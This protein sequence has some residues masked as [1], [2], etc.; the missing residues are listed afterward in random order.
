MCI[1][2]ITVEF[3]DYPL[4]GKVQDDVI[5][6]YKQHGRDPAVLPKL[7]QFVGGHTDFML[8]IKYLR[9]YPEKLFQLP[10]G[11]T[12]YRA[13][14]KNADGTRGFIG[15]PHKTFTEIDSKYQINTTTFISDQNKLFKAGYQVCPNPSLLHCKIE[16]D[17]L[18]DFMS[19]TNEILEPLNEE[20]KLEQ[21]HNSVLARNLKIFEEVENAGSEISCR[22]NKCQDC[23]ICKEHEQTEIMSIKEEVVKDVI[24]KS[25]S[26][27]I[28]KRIT[29][30]VL[31]FM[32]NPLG[33]LPHNKSKALQ[34]YNQQVKKLNMAP[35]DKQD[36]IE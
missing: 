31:S 17:C 30:A 12:I 23:K 15:G 16:K 1:D 33:K 29:T 28:K 14:F 20:M 8:G 34:V 11:L 22:C 4:K 3:L 36:V 7:A 6:S 18:N 19:N 13:W 9:Y 24:N 2:K 25:V 10:S 35:Q 5:N 21:L 26:V 32:F 27:D